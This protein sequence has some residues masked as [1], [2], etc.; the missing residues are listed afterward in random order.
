MTGTTPPTASELLML[1]GVS[2]VCAD[3]GDER[4]F[5]PVD[6][7]AHGASAY[8]CTGCDA[9]FFLPLP[10]PPASLLVRDVA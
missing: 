7:P 5:V 4:I 1:H 2:A 3:C 9:A 6:D 8:C 10:A